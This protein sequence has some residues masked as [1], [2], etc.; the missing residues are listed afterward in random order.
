MLLVFRFLNI[1]LQIT[2]MSYQQNAGQR[3]L[4]AKWKHFEVKH[5]HNTNKQ[6]VHST[7]VKCIPYLSLMVKRHRSLIHPT[8]CSYIWGFATGEECKLWWHSLRTLTIFVTN[9]KYFNL[10]EALQVVWHSKPSSF[11]CWAKTFTQRAK[12]FS[13]FPYMQTKQIYNYLFSGQREWHWLNK[14]C[15][16]MNANR[17]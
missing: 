10:V 6:N 8:L 5:E 12:V 11:I 1:H 15:I 14:D 7:H 4:T 2:G 13:S 17:N 16:M 9:L 3:W